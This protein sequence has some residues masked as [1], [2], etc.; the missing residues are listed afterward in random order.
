M[1]ELY[2]WEPHR[3]APYLVLVGHADAVVRTAKSPNGKHLW[4][5]AKRYGY[6]A[7]IDDAKDMVESLADHFTLRPDQRWMTL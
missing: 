6:E 3:S 4:Q 7:T 2:Q 5:Y 1:S